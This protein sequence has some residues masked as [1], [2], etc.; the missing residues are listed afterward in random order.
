MHKKQELNRFEIGGKILESTEK[1]TAEGLAYTEI[2]KFELKEISLISSET[3]LKE[4]EVKEKNVTVRQNES[5]SVFLEVIPSSG[6]LAH[7]ECDKPGV[8][9]VIDSYIPPA[10]NENRSGGEAIMCYTITITEPGIY[11]LAVFTQRPWN[12]EI[13]HKYLYRVT[14][15]A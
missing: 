6:F 3:T 15:T 5:F 11:H 14:V 10:D 1:V 2:S 4:F 8:M 9:F 13:G 12:K 7:Y